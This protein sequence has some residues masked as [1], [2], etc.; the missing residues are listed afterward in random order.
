MVSFVVDG[1]KFFGVWFINTFI[2]IVRQIDIV[3]KLFPLNFIN[4]WIR[5]LQPNMNLLGV[6]AI[7]MYVDS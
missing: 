5:K 4:V 7:H 6:L 1:S 2:G 3:G